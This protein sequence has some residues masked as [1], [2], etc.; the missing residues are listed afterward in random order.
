M[1]KLM[2]NGYEFLVGDNRLIVRY[3]GDIVLMDA[4]RVFNIKDF[5]LFDTD[6][7]WFKKRDYF[8]AMLKNYIREQKIKRII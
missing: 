7:D 4:G 2:I 5:D 1:K 6:E 8:R 3:E